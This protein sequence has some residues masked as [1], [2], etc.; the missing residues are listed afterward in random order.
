MNISNKK[1]KVALFDFC[2]TFINFQTGDAFIKYILG[3]PTKDSGNEQG[4]FDKRSRSIIHTLHDVVFPTP[5]SKILLVKRIKNIEAS[6]V[7]AKAKEYTTE[8]LLPNIV[9]ETSELFKRCKENDM[10]VV[11]VSAAYGVYL[12][13][14]SNK[15]PF[16]AILSSDLGIKDGKMTGRIVDDTIGKRKVARVKSFLNKKF[17]KN[18][19]TIE[20][21][22]GDSKSDMPILDMAQKAVVI[23]EKHQNW[24]KENY[25]EII[26]GH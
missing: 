12:R 7:E 25:E 24:L 19:Y 22:V 8:L 18:G 6:F 3:N 9:E 4:G 5:L 17:G 15:F 14:F 10:Y 26:Y 16:D 23:S 21:S 20:F 2:G 1:T 13:E 11:L